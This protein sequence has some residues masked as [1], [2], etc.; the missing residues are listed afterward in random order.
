[1]KALMKETGGTT[2]DGSETSILELFVQSG[3]ASS[4]GEAKKLIQGGG[5][6]LNE[7][8]ISDIGLKVT[9]S[10]LINGVLLLRKGKKA[11]RVISVD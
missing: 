6:S 4:N 5:I 1:M 2:R 11:F 3:L 9:K 10:D 8:K 7:E